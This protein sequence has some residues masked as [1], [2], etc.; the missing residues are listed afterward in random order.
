MRLIR[1]LGLA[2]LL[3][4][5]APAFADEG[6]PEVGKPAPEFE[7]P[8]VNISKA[9]PDAKGKKR[10]ALKNFQGVNGKNVVLFFYPKAM[11]GG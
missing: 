10:I 3:G 11:T 5:A 8:A 7:L 6:K 2:G 1:A 9:F 4:L